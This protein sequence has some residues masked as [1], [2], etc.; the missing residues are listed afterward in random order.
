MY[1]RSS[2]MRWR[3]S[4]PRPPHQELAI[5]LLVNF[6]FQPHLDAR[7]RIMA[8]KWLKKAYD[9]RIRRSFDYGRQLDAF[10]QSAFRLLRTRSPRAPSGEC[11]RDIPCPPHRRS[12]PSRVFPLT[13]LARLVMLLTW[14]HMW[15]HA[16]DAAGCVTD[17]SQLAQRVQ[18]SRR[19]APRPSLARA[20]HGFTSIKRAAERRRHDRAGSHYRFKLRAR[21]AVSSMYRRDDRHRPQTLIR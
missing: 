2:G 10:A 18:R 13:G 16:T 12:P 14:R 1:A 8:V 11:T 3:R 4:G 17:L 5:E 6:G 15:I 7:L 21:F 20:N 19:Y 9:P